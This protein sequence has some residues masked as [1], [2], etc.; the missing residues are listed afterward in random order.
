MDLPTRKE[1]EDA[2]FTVPSELCSNPESAHTCALIKVLMRSGKH[3]GRE[4]TVLDVPHVTVR[5]GSTVE[6]LLPGLEGVGTIV[7]EPESN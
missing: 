1:W 7:G 6:I 2:G 5:R 4:V 3:A